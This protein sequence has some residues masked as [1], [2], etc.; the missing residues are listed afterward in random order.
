MR[1]LAGSGW[2]EDSELLTS[3][4][5]QWNKQQGRLPEGSRFCFRTWEYKWLPEACLHHQK[6][7]RGWSRN[8]VGA[9]CMRQESSHNW[10]KHPLHSMWLGTV[11]WFGRNQ[12]YRESC[13]KKHWGNSEASGSWHHSSSPR[14]SKLSGMKEAGGQLHLK[15]FIK[16][17]RS[18][19]C[20]NQILQF[21]TQVSIWVHSGK[22]KS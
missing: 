3:C 4:N 14:T 17:E 10:P 11:V 18:E 16:P 6:E 1:E 21:K 20:L 5:P 8:E 9:Q 19:P 15:N 22:R 2:S 12:L 13:S 7:S